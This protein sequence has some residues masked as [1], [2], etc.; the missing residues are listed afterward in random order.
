M[1]DFRFAFIPALIL[2]I[3][4][5]IL[6]IRWWIGRS[7]QVPAVLR[8]SDTRLLAGLPSGMRV[9]LR[10]IPDFLRLVAWII[11]VIALARPQSGSGEEVVRGEGLDIVM[12]L[13]ISDSMATSDFNGLTRCD[14]AK[15]VLVDVINGRMN[16]RIG[17]VIFAEDAF[18][19][20]PPTTDYNILAE[21]IDDTRLAGDI[22]LSNRT[23]IGLGIASS[24]NLLRR[25]ASPS[26]VIILVTDG[27]NNAGEV[28]PISAAQAAAAF[29]VRIY[30]VGIGTTT[31][32][33]ALDEPTLRQIANIT[34]G[35]YFNASTLDGLRLVYEEIDTL[36]TSPI[37]RQLNIRWQDQAWS[38]MIIA[39]ALLIIE[40]ILRNTI[41]QTIP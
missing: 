13:D 38:F 5:L 8:Y 26:Q 29:G 22:G 9:R 17:L 3:P 39:L 33:D 2:F 28:D 10:Q 36:E 32:G 40:R 1:I 14:A 19:Q 30:T 7:N 25:S 16:A 27:S 24:T 31:Q 4:A 21:L 12:A 15:D 11:L 35:Q 18:Y 20:A 6:L 23:A 37:E 41:F 34:D